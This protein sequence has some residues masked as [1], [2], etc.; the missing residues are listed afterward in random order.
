[1]ALR[2]QSGAKGPADKAAGTRENYAHPGK[3]RAKSGAAEY[4]GGVRYKAGAMIS[5][6]SASVRFSLLLAVV[7]LSLVGALF[8]LDIMEGPLAKDAALKVVYV[9]AVVA[10]LG[11]VT[12]MISSPGSK[13]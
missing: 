3:V 4:P 10:A 7:L 2:G 13:K 5:R 6:L 9:C 1:M 11:A 12:G 8:L